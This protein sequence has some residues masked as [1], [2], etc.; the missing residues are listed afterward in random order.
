MDRPKKRV[1]IVSKDDTDTILSQLAK[2]PE[3][4]A[5]AKEAYINGVDTLEEYKANKEAIETQR[6]L[7]EASLKNCK[8]TE[9]I[10][11][12]F[13]TTLK[14]VYEKLIDENISAKEKFNISHTIIDK[15]E[16][17]KSAQTL[18]LSYKYQM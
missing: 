2:L 4:E 14:T 16:F 15:V 17:D 7:L 11:N 8:K 18:Y 10:E 3:K 6:K 1:K 13:K 9:N 5:R 12:D